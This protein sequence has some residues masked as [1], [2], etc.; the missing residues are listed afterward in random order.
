MLGNCYILTEVWSWKHL[1]QSL[2]E[3]SEFVKQ[4]LA[5]ENTAWHHIV[6]FVFGDQENNAK[7]K[8]VQNE[9][10]ECCTTNRSGRWCRRSQPGYLHLGKFQGHHNQQI[11]DDRSGLNLKATNRVHHFLKITSS[12][13]I[14]SE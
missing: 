8:H 4:Q 3:N 5:V 2:K 14:H 10:A 9:G 7:E 13:C 6:K 1:E 12:L 11:N